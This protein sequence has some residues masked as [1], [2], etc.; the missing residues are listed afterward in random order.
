MIDVIQQPA[1]AAAA[2]DNYLATAPRC[3]VI[4]LDWQSRWLDA[5]TRPLHAWHGPLVNAAVIYAWSARRTPACSA[6]RSIRCN[7]C[8]NIRRAAV[9]GIFRASRL[10][11][12]DRA[13]S[14][15]PQPQQQQQQRRW[16]PSI[17]LWSPSN[18]DDITGRL[19]ASLW[20]AVALCLQ[21]NRGICSHIYRRPS[22][23]SN[24]F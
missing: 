8:H 5:S 18:T 1:A 22:Q 7:R 15:E 16:Q 20:R 12:H 11:A 9:R 19:C 3:V 21:E 6:R 13:S 14:T 24:Q 2:K 4:V 10:T 23:R 17:D